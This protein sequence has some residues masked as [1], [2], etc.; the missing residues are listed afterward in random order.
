MDTVNQTILTVA[1]SLVVL[2]I[3]YTTFRYMYF[4]KHEHFVCL[5]CKTAFKPK[6]LSLIFSTNAVEGKIIKCPH[7]GSKEYMEPVRDT[8]V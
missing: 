1:I 7:C 2:V 6:I 3:L 4:M 5:K 8:K